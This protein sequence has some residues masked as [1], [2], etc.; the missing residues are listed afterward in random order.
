MFCRGTVEN[1]PSH[2]IAEHLCSNTRH[3]SPREAA[4][5]LRCMR[6]LESNQLYPERSI[7]A[8]HHR[9]IS[10]AKYPHSSPPTNCIQGN[11][12]RRHGSIYS[13]SIPRLHHLEFK[14]LLRFRMTKASE[15]LETKTPPE[16]GSE[17]FE[18]NEL[19]NGV[20][21][22]HLHEKACAR[23]RRLEHTAQIRSAASDYKAR[24]FSSAFSV[25][26]AP[27]AHE[28]RGV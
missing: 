4:S 15:R 20:S 18:R 8:L 27:I 25:S 2:A 13:R 17:G 6:R 3:D 23:Q 22:F 24:C 12:R 5:T 1:G 7:R 26:R 19:K 28:G 14:T 10:R 11:E 16:L 21:P 9:Q